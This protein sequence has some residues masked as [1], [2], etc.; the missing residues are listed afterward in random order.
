VAPQHARSSLFECPVAP[1]R[2]RKLRTGYVQVTCKLFK[3][4]AGY[5]QVTS[6]LQDPDTRLQ[7]LESMN[8]YLFCG[9]LGMRLRTSNVLQMWS[10]QLK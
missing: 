2:L 1:V 9:C 3:L 4:R 7:R 10:L 5:A 8:V 6:Y